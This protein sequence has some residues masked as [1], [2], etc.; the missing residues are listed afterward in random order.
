MTLYKRITQPIFKKAAKNT[1]GVL[2][3]IASNI[4]V[5]RMALYNWI[6]KNKGYADPILLSE[7]ETLLDT[8]EDKLFEQIHKGDSK[9]INFALSTIGK[10]RGYVQKQEVEQT[11]K[12][13]PIEIQ[14]RMP[15]QITDKTDIID[16]KSKEVK[17][18]GQD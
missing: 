13:D 9:A 5:S 8:A 14:V 11:G 6:Q 3:I 16:G 12:M 2:N 10:D 4:G 1:R 7:R 17:D 15:S 18:D